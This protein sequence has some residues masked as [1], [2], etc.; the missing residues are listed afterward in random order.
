MHRSLSNPKGPQNPC[1][2]MESLNLPIHPKKI[3][4][5]HGSRKA[6]KASILLDVLEVTHSFLHPCGWQL[7]G[8]KE[9]MLPCSIPSAAGMEVWEQPASQREQQHA[10][11]RKSTLA[12]LG[13]RLHCGE[14]GGT[15]RN[16]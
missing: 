5:L 6:V 9:G 3:C 7:E 15:S 16:L 1:L 4:L 8:R 10:V 13:K 14:E 12:E 11:H 2:V